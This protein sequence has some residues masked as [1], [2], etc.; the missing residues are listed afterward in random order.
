MSQEQREGLEG[1]HHC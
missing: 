1:P